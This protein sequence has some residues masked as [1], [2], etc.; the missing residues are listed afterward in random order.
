MKNVFKKCLSLLLVVTVI[1][2]SSYIGFVESDCVSFIFNPIKSLIVNTVAADESVFAFTLNSDGRSYSVKGNDITT[3]GEIVI[4]S[5]YNGLPVTAIADKAFYSYRELTSV[6]IPDGVTLIG[7]SAF[8]LCVNLV[9]IDIPETVTQI[10]FSA[11]SSCV[12]LESIVLPYGI[13]EIS[14]NMFNVAT[15]S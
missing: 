9:N 6:I 14:D 15:N 5:T 1:F 12:P 8:K 11:F 7:S 10:K 13:T 3:T 2:G 4:P